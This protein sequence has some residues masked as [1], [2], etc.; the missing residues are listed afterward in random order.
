VP[1]T[2]AKDQVSGRARSF[3][4]P[5]AVSLLSR[6]RIKPEDPPRPYSESEALLASFRDYLLEER[7]LAPNTAMA[8][9]LRART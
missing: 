4:H 8:Y 2:P 3:G 1:A 5:Q 6:S 9:V 7:G